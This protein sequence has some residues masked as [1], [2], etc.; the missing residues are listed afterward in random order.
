VRVVERHAHP[1]FHAEAQGSFDVG[2]GEF[3]RRGIAG[4]K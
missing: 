1:D 4:G 3:L 2:Y